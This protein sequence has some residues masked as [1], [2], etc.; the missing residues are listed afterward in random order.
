[1]PLA[2]FNFLENVTITHEEASFSKTWLAFVIGSFQ[3]ETLGWH[4]IVGF[5]IS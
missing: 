4:V 1:M 3:A 5:L 2:M